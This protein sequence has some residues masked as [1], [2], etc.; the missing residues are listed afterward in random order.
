MTDTSIKQGKPWAKILLVVSL[1]LNLAVAGLVIGAKMS[2]H[3][4]G[5][6]PYAGG[7]GMRVLMHALPKSKRTEARKFFH[8]NREK[9]RT[10]GDAMR[11]SLDDIGAAITAR[12]FDAGT[13][14]EAF[15][16]QRAHIE[17]MTQD[18]QQAFVAIIAGMTDEE[19]MQ[20]V[21]NMKKQR[22]KWRKDH[23]RKSKK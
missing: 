23:T 5:K 20:Y 15:S 18:A 16:N 21:D 8:Q 13:L 22:Q 17:T 10:N 12:P 9:H 4:P 7:T 11:V 19:R 2:G 3:G 6:S 1:G 14:R